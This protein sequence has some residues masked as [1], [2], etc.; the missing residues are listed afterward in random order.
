[1]DLQIAEAL[2]GTKHYSRS[3]ILRVCRS[4]ASEKTKSRYKITGLWPFIKILIYLSLAAKP[5]PNCDRIWVAP[6]LWFSPVQKI[7]MKSGRWE[8]G[9]F[10]DNCLIQF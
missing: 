2:F 10:K 1:M 8:N 7:V 9:A 6:L 4:D 3:K 5:T